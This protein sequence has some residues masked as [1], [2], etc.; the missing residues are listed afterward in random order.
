[1]NAAEILALIKLI[2]DLEPAA[3]QAV[4]ALVDKLKGLTPDQIAALTVQI[5]NTAISEI[6]AE[7]A[8]L[9]PATPPAA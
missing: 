8:K 2:T 4:Q 9:P 3:I 6:D 7:L 1:M 5:N